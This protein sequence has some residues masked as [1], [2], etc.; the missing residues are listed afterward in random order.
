MIYMDTDSKFLFCNGVFY[1]HIVVDL[2]KQSS[3]ENGKIN[4]DKLIVSICQNSPYKFR[5]LL[6]K[7]NF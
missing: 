5:K 1:S 6:R 7:K 2:E 4:I 3:E